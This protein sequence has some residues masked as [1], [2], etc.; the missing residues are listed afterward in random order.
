MSKAH[1]LVVDDEPSARTG[2]EKLLRREGYDVTV[3]EDG[4]VVYFPRRMSS[5]CPSAG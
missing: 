4:A 1:L 3:A 2:L 5:A